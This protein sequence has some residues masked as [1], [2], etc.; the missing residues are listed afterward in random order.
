MK[1]S[2]L[3]TKHHDYATHALIQEISPVHCR[4]YECEFNCRA[5]TMSLD[6][7]RAVYNKYKAAENF[8]WMVD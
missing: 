6:L 5:P 2:E 7:V 4:S 3:N 8:M 1:I